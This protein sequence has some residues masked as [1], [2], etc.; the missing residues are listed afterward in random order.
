MVGS[1]TGVRSLA[2][3]N[4]APDDEL[5]RAELASCCAARDWGA[6]LVAG[7]PYAG[8]AELCAASDA[9]TLA[10]TDVGLAEALAGHPRIGDRPHGEWSRQE[11]SGMSAADASI[12]AELAAANAAYEQRFGQIYLVCASGRSAEELLAVCLSRLAND[13]ATER[14]VVLGELAKINRIR[15][16]KLLDEGDSE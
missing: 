4:D 9:A 3:F 5:L 13:P 10:L 6:A 7:R 8:L 11:Q 12:R 14:G 15:L 2:A 16:E 1:S